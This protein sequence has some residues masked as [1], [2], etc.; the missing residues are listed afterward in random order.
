MYGQLGDGWTTD[1]HSF[2]RV[3][4]HGANVISAGTFHTM[5]V[6]RDGGILATGLNKDGQFGDGSTVSTKTF[7]R[8]APFTS[9]LKPGMSMYTFLVS[10][11]FYTIVRKA[12]S[13]QQLSQRGRRIK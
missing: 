7:V 9:E 5:V 6:T 8:L 2:V 1:C 3:I 13:T 12:Q 11:H 10:S 4:S